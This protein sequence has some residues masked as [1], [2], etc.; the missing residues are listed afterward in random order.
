MIFKY[1]SFNKTMNQ[2]NLT[3]GQCAKD[4]AGFGVMFFIVFFAFAQLGYLAFGTQSVA[5]QRKIKSDLACNRDPH[6]LL[7]PVINL[8]RLKSL[9][10]FRIILGDFDFQ[11]LH[12]ANRVLGPLYFLVYIFFVFFVL[13]NMFIAIIN[14]T[15]L[16]VKSN[17]LNQPSEVQMKTFFKKRLKE[18]RTKTKQKKAQ[19]REIQNVLDAVDTEGQDMTIEDFKSE[20]KDSA[21][22][23]TLEQVFKKGDINGDMKLSAEERSALK[24]TLESKKVSNHFA[25]ATELY[26]RLDTSMVLHRYFISA[27]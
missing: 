19:L 6:Q 2:L 1:V 24:K 21:G 22:G 17:L 23:L 15:Y 12:E 8:P 20:M 4:I 13:I 18:I 26:H 5:A 7:D 27:G 11:A 9:T 3:L 16:D 25:L 14:D 10:L